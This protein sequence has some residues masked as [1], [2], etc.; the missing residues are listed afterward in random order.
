MFGEI[1]ITTT[2]SDRTE[3]F[4]FG[5]IKLKDGASVIIKTADDLHIGFDSLG[6]SGRAGGFEE[7]E[8]LVKLGDAFGEGIVGDF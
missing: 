2:A 4:I 7:I 6:F 1:V 8:N 5:E 3:V